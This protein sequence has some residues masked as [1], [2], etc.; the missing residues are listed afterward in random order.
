MLRSTPSPWSALMIRCHLPSL[1]AARKLRIAEVARLSGL[2]RST[3][4]ALYHGRATRIELP[5]LDRLCKV[6]ACRVGELLEWV[7][8]PEGDDK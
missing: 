5:A 1:M 6:F 2:N 4:G 3:I 8:N 7:E